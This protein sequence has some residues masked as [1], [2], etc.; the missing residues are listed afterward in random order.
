MASGTGI[1]I[2]GAG[3]LYGTQPEADVHLGVSVVQLGPHRAAQLAELRA[4]H[5][6]ARA[7]RSALLAL[8][9]ARTAMAAAGWEPGTAMGINVGSARG[10]TEQLEYH[11]RQF[12]YQGYTHS[13]ASP[14]TTAGQLAAQLAQQ[15]GATTG[16]V[17]SHSI[18]CSSAGF[19]LANAVAWLRAGMVSRFLAGGAEAP[20]TPFVVA[21]MQALGIYAAAEAPYTAWPCRP[22]SAQARGMILGEGAALF[23][24]TTETAGAQARILGLGFGNERVPSA[25]GITPTGDCLYASMQAALA[26]AGCTPDAVDL[27]LAHAP[28]TRVGDSAEQAALGRLFGTR[29]PARYSTKWYT[30]HTFGASA[31]ISLLVAMGLLQGEPLP[32]VP[33]ESEMRA[34]EPDQVQRILI[35]S[36]GFGG[37]AVSI[38]ISRV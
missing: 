36:V 14:S 24:L 6:L 28:G 31:G 22:L 20:L 10:A 27:V 38:L 17:F 16:P 33:F 15:L 1:Y 19:A 30:G 32:P 9:A 34:P 26:D 37:N 21:Q 4:T 7:D 23:A 35:N 29:M 5:A 3:G 11:H 2:V 13:Q 25:T 18:T 8:L 12:I